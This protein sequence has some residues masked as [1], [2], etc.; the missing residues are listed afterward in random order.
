MTPTEIITLGLLAALLAFSAALAALILTGRGRLEVD[1]EHE[2]ADEQ[3]AVEL[4][5]IREQMA[6]DATR[7]LPVVTETGPVSHAVHRH[8]S[9]DE[10]APALIETRE[11]PAV[12]LLKDLPRGE[13]LAALER[14][15]WT[16]GEMRS[17][18]GTRW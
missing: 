7:V 11:L 5:D 1:D 13:L 3:F 6:N 12:D 16:R 14:G 17:N 18:A 15:G 10:R 2:G 9:G 8:T 4:H